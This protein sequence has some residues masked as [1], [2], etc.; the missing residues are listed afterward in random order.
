MVCG[1]DPIIHYSYVFI[2]YQFTGKLTVK[3]KIL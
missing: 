3:N 1:Y 2:I